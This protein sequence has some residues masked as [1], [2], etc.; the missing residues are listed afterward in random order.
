MSVALTTGDQDEAAGHLL[1]MLASAKAAS[2]TARKDSEV[3]V[4]CTDGGNNNSSLG[5]IK[6]IDYVIILQTGVSVASDEVVGSDAE[7]GLTKCRFQGEHYTA[8]EDCVQF[9]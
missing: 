3:A 4:R 7:I 8:V 9:I 1:K 5:Q 6:S 2:A